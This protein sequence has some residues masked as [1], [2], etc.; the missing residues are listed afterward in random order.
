LEPTY[1][2]GV[3][4]VGGTSIGGPLLPMVLRIKAEILRSL[5]EEANT[6]NMLKWLYSPIDVGVMNMNLL[7]ADLVSIGSYGKGEHDG[8]DS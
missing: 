5:G 4:M 6:N 7:V 8:D 1:I 3:E 2:F